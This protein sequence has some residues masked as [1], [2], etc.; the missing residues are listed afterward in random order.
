MKRSYIQRGSYQWKSRS[1]LMQ[2]RT[3]APSFRVT[4]DTGG[5]R[6]NP[7]GKKAKLRESI[8][9]RNRARFR[10]MGLYD[11]CEARL[12]GCWN[13]DLTWAHGRKDRELSMAERQ[14]LVI[15]ACTPCHRILDEEM[16]RQEMLEFV[17]TV[18]TNRKVEIMGSILAVLLAAPS[19]GE[20]DEPDE[21]A[22]AWADDKLNEVRSVLDGLACP[23]IEPKCWCYG[24]IGAHLL[25]DHLPSCAAAHALYKRLELRDNAAFVR[26]PPDAPTN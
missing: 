22:V 7:V 16:S 20:N 1:R 21:D 25:G 9:R 4:K 15:R 23:L 17:E 24:T 12:D 10:A 8:N 19:A 26:L 3:L 18:I 13:T 11:V 6:L 2:N 14:F 5:R